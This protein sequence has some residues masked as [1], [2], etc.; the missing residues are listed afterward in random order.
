V[1]L[2]R[3]GTAGLLASY[4]GL[5]I[6]AQVLNNE[7]ALS[8]AQKE[9][10]DVVLMQVQ[11]CFERSRESLEKLREISPA[12]KVIIVTMFEEPRYVRELM[13]LGTSA[14]LLKSAS[15]AYL[16]GAVRA[17]VFDPEGHH[18]V[19]GMP[20]QMIEEVEGGSGG[21][22]TVREMEILLLVARGLSNGQRARSLSVSEATVKRHLANAY[23]KMGV[24]SRSQA[25]R[26]ALF[27]HWITIEDFT[28]R[29]SGRKKTAVGESR[30]PSSRPTRGEPRPLIIPATQD[31]PLGLLDHPE[32]VFDRH[33]LF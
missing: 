16:T 6:I 13:D 32:Q 33:A 15:V 30:N 20:Q 29:R 11:M 18:V 3:R 31:Q 7:G 28:R 1:A 8:I 9:K 5:E 10:P 22:L 19:V 25:V 4:G 23:P 24:A 17:A 2:F 12:P 21:V 26:K 27:E 14:Y